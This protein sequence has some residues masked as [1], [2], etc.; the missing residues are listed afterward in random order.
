[1]SRSLIIGASVRLAIPKE[2]RSDRA[3]CQYRL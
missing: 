1:M 2:G 3:K